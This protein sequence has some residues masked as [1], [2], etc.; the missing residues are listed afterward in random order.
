MANL[1][2]EKIKYQNSKIIDEVEQ[3]HVPI[4][5]KQVYLI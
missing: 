5:N 2:F 3:K 1:I 4:I